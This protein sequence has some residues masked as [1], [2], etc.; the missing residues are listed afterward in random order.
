[1]HSL[2]WVLGFTISCLLGHFV[3]GWFH[4]WLTGRLDLCA[5]LTEKRTPPPLTGLLERV[6]FTV[7]VAMNAS[8]VLPAMMTWLV[9]KLAANWQYRDDTDS[10]VTKANRKFRAILAGLVSMLFAYVGGLLIMHCVASAAL[11]K[12]F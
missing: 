2:D 11:S 10:P 4:R 8:G 7:A 5:N 6:F 12:I 1:M 9:L 3:V